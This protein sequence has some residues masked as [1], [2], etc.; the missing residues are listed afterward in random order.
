MW[1]KLLVAADGSP[2]SGAATQLALAIAA[3][4]DAR[5]DA[6]HVVDTAMM[7][8][9]FIADLSGSVGFQ[10][11]LNLT[12][13]MREALRAMGASILEDFE[14]RRSGA[15]VPG[16]PRT[17]EGI[18]VNEVART[19]EK[20]DAVFVGAHGVGSKRGKPIGSHADALLRRL[21]IP[22]FVAREGCTAISRPLAA[23]DGSEKANR[24]LQAAAKLAE[25]FGVPLAVLSSGPEAESCRTAADRIVSETSCRYS[26]QTAPGHPDDEILKRLP[27]HDLVALGSHGHGRIIEFVLGSTTERVLRKSPVTVLCVP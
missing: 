17:A 22:A 24:A 7:D 21:S 11:F 20:Y 26:F 10:P 9:T 15:G 3:R 13:E 14:A 25:L 27:E 8:A 23:F 2:D 18:V 6:I 16:A 12:A 19:A 1:N 4:S 5:V